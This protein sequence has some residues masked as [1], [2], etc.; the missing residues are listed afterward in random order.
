MPS[1]LQ[2]VGGDHGGGGKGD[3]LEGVI[4]LGKACDGPEE[5]R[6]EIT[7]WADAREDVQSYVIGKVVDLWHG[8]FEATDSIGERI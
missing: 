2:D 5:R 4:E 7:R 3:R 1:L 8:P 6:K